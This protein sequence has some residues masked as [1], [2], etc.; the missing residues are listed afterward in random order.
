MGI[1]FVCMVFLNIFGFS[2]VFFKGI[3]ILF[4]MMRVLWIEIRVL[5]L[6]IILVQLLVEH[7][8]FWIE[9]KVQI[10]LG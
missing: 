3:V 5:I 1:V 2:R 4:L 9:R 6:S 8:V 10:C 7:D